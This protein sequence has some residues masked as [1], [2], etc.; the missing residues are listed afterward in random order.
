MKN[1]GGFE[2]GAVAGREQLQSEVLQLLHG[3]T[4]VRIPPSDQVKSTDHAIDFFEPKDLLNL[5]EGV[6][7]ARV[8]ASGYDNRTQP[9]QIHQ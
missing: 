3:P 2:S 7:Y 4:N 6:H 5:K 1:A 9:L 8:G